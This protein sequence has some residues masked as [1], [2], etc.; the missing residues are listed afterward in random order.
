MRAIILDLQ[1][2]PP[3]VALLEAR[4]FA[5]ALDGDETAVSPALQR[6]AMRQ[7]YRDWHTDLSCSHRL[8]SAETLV[9]I[10]TAWADAALDSEIRRD[11]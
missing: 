11:V 8:R 7:A 1:N 6:R 5:K 10:T 3:H 4:L 2:L 9:K